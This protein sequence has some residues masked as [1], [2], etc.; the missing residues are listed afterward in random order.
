MKNNLM[1]SL[2]IATGAAL[3]EFFNH[4]LSAMDYY[5]PIV[6]FIIAFSLTSFVH[7]SKNEPKSP[8]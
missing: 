5:K 6:I 7:S 2:G 1:V 4:G 3:Y 8:E